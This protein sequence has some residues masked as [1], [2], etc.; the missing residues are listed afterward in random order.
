MFYHSKLALA[1]RKGI[2]QMVENERLSTATEE[3][4]QLLEKHND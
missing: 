1:V 3:Q 2:D 4:K